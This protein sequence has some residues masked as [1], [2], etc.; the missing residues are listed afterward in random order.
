MQDILL[1]TRPFLANIAVPPPLLSDRGQWL[2]VTTPLMLVKDEVKYE[3]Y[4][5][6]A[7]LNDVKGD[8]KY[9][10]CATF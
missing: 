10:D 7:L 6:T 1:T 8:S 5:F 4:T 3:H 2:R 9:A